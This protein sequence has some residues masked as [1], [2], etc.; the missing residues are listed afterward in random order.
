MKIAWFTPYTIQ[1]AIARYSHAILLELK[2]THEVHLWTSSRKDLPESPVPIHTFSN[3]NEVIGPLSTYDVVIYNLG[4]NYL[5]H[6]EIYDVLT[7]IPGIVI[8][9]D[10]CMH[11]FFEAYYKMN[12]KLDIYHQDLRTLYGTSSIN[13]VKTTLAHNYD[14]ILES[15]FFVQYP[16]FEKSVANATAVITHSQFLAEK[17]QLCYP[18]P[19]ENIPLPH[20]DY[21]NISTLSEPLENLFPF[22]SEKKI[23]ILTTGV[24][25]PN[26]RV[27]RGI[28]ILMDNPDLSR[29]VNYVVIGGHSNK[30]YISQLKKQ[31][32]QGKLESCVHLLGY[33]PDSILMKFMERADICLNLRYPALEGGSA[34]IVEQL[35]FGK[36]SIVTKTGVYDEL[37][38]N[39]VRKISPHNEYHDLTFALKSLIDSQEDRSSLSR[40]AKQYVNDNLTPSKFCERLNHF[41]DRA[42]YSAPIQNLVQTVCL[43]LTQIGANI[44]SES[45]KTISEELEHLY[46]P[47]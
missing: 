10:F 14:T 3:S 33:Q 39:V 5:Y 32:H 45:L 22:L 31:I 23:L 19:V 17:V 34:S 44:E 40:A 8:L 37:P 7:R 4:D 38:D 21:S 9:H 18:G 36:P 26:K 16:L 2:K 6:G 24:V 20:F 27:H 11:H 1:S 13:T 30:S 35:F 41:L 46:P 29:Q 25:N 43:Q 12:D 47:A 28:D 15:D 42:R